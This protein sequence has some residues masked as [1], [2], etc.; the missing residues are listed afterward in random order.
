MKLKCFILCDYN[1][2]LEEAL[3]MKYIN[4]SELGLLREWREDPE[5]W[6]K[7]FEK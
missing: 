1:G 5:S 6:T 3:H 4:E 2:L 7:K